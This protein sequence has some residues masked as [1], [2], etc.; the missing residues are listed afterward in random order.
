MFCTIVRAGLCSQGDLLNS[1]VIEIEAGKLASATDG[2]ATVPLAA[3]PQSQSHPRAL[4]TL[5][6]LHL[7]PSRSQSSLRGYRIPRRSRILELLSTLQGRRQLCF[8]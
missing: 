5:L 3:T 1:C 4:P 6:I 2:T 8:I 7:F